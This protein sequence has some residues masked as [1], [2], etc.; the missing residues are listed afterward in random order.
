MFVLA[1]SY[2]LQVAEALNALTWLV[3]D[4]VTPSPWTPSNAAVNASTNDSLRVANNTDDSES[5]GLALWD[6]ARCPA[7]TDAKLAFPLL[8]ALEIA[9]AAYVQ[10]RNESQDLR[11]KDLPGYSAEQV[12]FLTACHVTCSKEDSGPSS[13]PICTAAMR[14][15]KPFARAFSCRAGSPM[16][17]KNKCQFFSTSNLSKELNPRRCQADYLQPQRLIALE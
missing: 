11:L 10:F 3:R 1:L 9:H 8:P 6:L 7:P 15:F 17:P 5:S 2:R 14:N 12:F 16:N 13:S 4:G